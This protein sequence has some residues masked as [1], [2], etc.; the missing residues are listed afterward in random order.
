MILSIA[1]CIMPMHETDS[2]GRLHHPIKEEK[3]RCEK[4]VAGNGDGDV[5]FFTSNAIR[6]M[7]LIDWA[8]F[9]VSLAH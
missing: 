8:E 1:K 6:P 2:N 7:G 3:R 4:I 5:P 9:N